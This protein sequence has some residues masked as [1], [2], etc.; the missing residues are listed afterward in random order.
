MGKPI[1]GD[2]FEDIFGPIS[3][4]SEQSKPSQFK[5]HEKPNVE[6]S[7]GSNFKVHDKRINQTKLSVSDIY[8]TDSDS[9]VDSAMNKFSKMCSP[10][11]S[12]DEKS[13]QNKLDHS[14]RPSTDVESYS[15]YKFKSEEIQDESTDPKKKKKKK[16]NKEHKVNRRLSRSDEFSDDLINADIES[17]V[18]QLF[19]ESSDN[20][21]A[22][23]SV[24]HRKKKK[25]KKKKK[26]LSLIPLL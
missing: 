9:N 4:D 20:N 3:D 26:V 10:E 8:G 19:G 18:S 16:K 24:D 14:R 11:Y 21:A 17:K 22:N 13:I 23:S 5:T 7:K 1:K 6:K 15:Y 2:K 25:K 12:K